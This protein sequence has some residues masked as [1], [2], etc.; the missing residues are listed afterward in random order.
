MKRD[1]NFWGE[2]FRVKP[3]K[4]NSKFEPV[5]QTGELW[6]V[7]FNVHIEMIPRNTIVLT[8]RS[9][10]LRYGYICPQCRC[11]AAPS[12][13]ELPAP[14]LLLKIRSDLKNAMKEKDTAR[15][16]VLRGLLSEVTNAAKTNNPVKTDMQLLS[17]LKKRAAAAKQASD[18]FKSAGRQD[19]VDKEE[20]Q[21]KV[22]AEYAGDVR[23]MSN[24]EIRDEVMKVVEEVKAQQP[25]KINMGDVLKRLLS[26]GGSL[27]GKPVE[28]SEVARIVKEVLTL[29]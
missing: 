24:N 6:V 16:N 17:V 19:L 28:R 23:T 21:A 27:D 5:E 14:P 11:Y 13:S 1:Q 18:E 22:L 12:K 2:L 29:S 26:P 15:L 10:Y 20:G 4:L 7:I 25:A 8:R 3:E 9:Q